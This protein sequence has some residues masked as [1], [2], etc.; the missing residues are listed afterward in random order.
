MGTRAFQPE[1]RQ[2]LPLYG[3]PPSVRV[4]KG[5]PAFTRSLPARHGFSITLTTGSGRE[6]RAVLVPHPVV[7]GGGDPKPIVAGRKVRVVGRA[8]VVGG[9]PGL[10]EA[11]QGVP[12]EH[13]LRGEEAQ[14]RVVELELLVAGSDAG[15]LFEGRRIVVAQHA[16]AGGGAVP[17]GSARRGPH[18]RRPAAAGWDRG[19]GGHPLG[20]V[21]GS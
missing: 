6:R 3:T 4:F 21:D 13:L 20:F 2:I 12:E 1:G 15:A 7:V 17:E 18:R 11:L 5:S 9:R 19:H 8:P 14:R 10:V 16:L